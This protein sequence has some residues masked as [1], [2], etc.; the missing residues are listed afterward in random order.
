M[1][2]QL[3]LV[4]ICNIKIDILKVIYKKIIKEKYASEVSIRHKAS[5]LLSN[6]FK[7][8]MS[9]N[10]DTFY[11]LSKKLFAHCKNPLMHLITFSAI[12]IYGESSKLKLIYLRAFSKEIIEVWKLSEFSSLMAEAIRSTNDIEVLNAIFTIFMPLASNNKNYYNTLRIILNKY[13]TLESTYE[14][15][16]NS[17]KWLTDFSFNV[18]RS[19]EL[20]NLQKAFKNA[21]TLLPNSMLAEK[22][23][24]LQIERIARS[25]YGEFAL[26]YF[27]PLI[28]RNLSLGKT[29][30]DITKNAWTIHAIHVLVKEK[31]LLFELAYNKL[32][33]F[34]TYLS[35]FDK[36]TAKINLSQEEALIIKNLLEFYEGFE[37][38]IEHTVRLIR[39]QA[40]SEIEE[41]K[42]PAATLSIKERS[43]KVLVMYKRLKQVLKYT[44]E[45]TILNKASKVMA[46]IAPYIYKHGMDYTITIPS[47]LSRIAGNQYVREQI[48]REKINLY[49][50]VLIKKEGFERIIAAIINYELK[51]QTEAKRKVELVEI[52]EGKVKF[53]PTFIKKDYDKV[54]VR[55]IT[56]YASRGSNEFELPFFEVMCLIDKEEIH[57]LPPILFCIDQAL[58]STGES[59]IALKCLASFCNQTTEFFSYALYVFKNEELLKKVIKATTEDDCIV[60]YRELMKEAFKYKVAKEITMRLVKVALKSNI[61]IEGLVVILRG[62]KKVI[63]EVYA[64]RDIPL[65][66]RKLFVEEAK[67]DIRVAVI[68]FIRNIGKLEG[69][70]SGKIKAEW[71]KALIVLFQHATG[72]Y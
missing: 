3:V 6:Y 45:K 71:V 7:Q 41:S 23:I 70:K 16:I 56:E 22:L 65:E 57:K 12:M 60:I 49:E 37:E 40:K 64:N 38:Y 53:K 1:K 25:S 31:L 68:D 63:K 26:Q 11:Y 36:T 24:L 48:D 34:E 42:A 39:R 18:K 13:M 44:N 35:S 21:L 4:F 20:F 19:Q 33:H 14:L 59:A 8:C 55:V 50:E 9:N 2:K 51:I 10:T 17:I 66:T 5:Y 62:I 58:K 15:K 27:F 54:Y 69:S 29:S 46:I 32:K 67:Q 30:E 61:R 72:I 52:D 28:L 47:D 43:E